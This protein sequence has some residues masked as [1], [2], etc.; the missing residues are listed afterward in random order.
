MATLKICA[1]NEYKSSSDE[2][3]ILKNKKK[4]S[5]M[6][7]NERKRWHW[8]IILFVGSILVY[9]VR[10][11]MSVCVPAIAKEMGWSKQ[12]SGMALSAFFFGYLSTNIL[13]GYFADR[14]GG[15]RMI[16]YSSTIWA[17]LTVVLPYFST[18]QTFLN[19]G[20]FAIL[21]TR[22]FTGCA[23]GFF[24]PS[25]SSLV[26]K[27]VKDSDKGFVTGVVFS[28]C[29]IGTIATGFFGSII[30]EHTSWRFV[31]VLIGG[32]SM[33]W[34][35]AFRF[36][37]HV[38]KNSKPKTT[39]DFSS[40][41]VNTES[42]PWRRLLR[43]ASVWA[44]LVAFFAYGYTFYV[45]LSWAPAY[46]HDA[47][48]ESKGWIFNVIPWLASFA[49]QNIAGY[50]SNTLMSSGASTTYVRKL[51][52]AMLF[53]GTGLF[54][55]LLNTVESFQQALFVMALT[56]GVN[57]FSTSSISLNAQDLS[58]K[59]A[60]AL[61]GFG[62]SLSALGGSIGVYLTGWILEHS[63]RWSYVFLINSAISFFAFIVFQL[64]GSAEAVV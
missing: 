43:R 34:I 11:S 47:F 23:Q 52:A 18:A 3:L 9:C 39:V 30:M 17:T 53:L 63:G 60:G 31:F 12:I 50:Y 59:H 19:S 27:H 58:P 2:E 36:Y 61:F 38:D 57:A 33:L 25:L 13:G 54:S 64:F 24:Y 41:K 15:E 46:F 10:T 22:F 20:T 35:Y 55:L 14:H 16:M 45:L 7:W 44:F 51:Y 37:Y 49:V 40:H 21:A 42:F 4:D 56:V 62:N 32:F 29:S 28:G 6:F 48:P 8:T 5:D 1:Q 26:S